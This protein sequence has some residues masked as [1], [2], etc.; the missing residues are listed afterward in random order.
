MLA[1][2]PLSSPMA[3]VS[4]SCHNSV[5][6][7]VGGGCVCGYSSYSQVFWG[8]KPGNLDIQWEALFWALE[9]TDKADTFLVP[10]RILRI[11]QERPEMSHISLGQMSGDRRG[12][13]GQ[14]STL[15][16][17]CQV[18][19]GRQ[20][21]PGHWHFHKRAPMAI[22]GETGSL[23]GYTSVLSLGKAP[24]SLGRA[25]PR[26]VPTFSTLAFTWVNKQHAFLA[27]S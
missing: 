20:G 13:A 5:Y 18:C 25:C 21:R 1:L 3:F 12:T 19:L 24:M 6:S 4:K 2:P 8:R 27:L 16:W 7:F 15:G 11:C 23:P 22:V 17:G 9:D 14:G 10:G 26:F